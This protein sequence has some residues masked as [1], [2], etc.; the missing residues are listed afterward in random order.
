SATTA[1]GSN[2]NHV[3]LF[4]PDRRCEL[5]AEIMNCFTSSAS[6]TSTVSA[7]SPIPNQRGQRALSSV[8][9]CPR[10][11]RVRRRSSD[12]TTPP[13][14][15]HHGPRRLQRSAA[16]QSAPLPHPAPRLAASTSLP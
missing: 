1:Q 5:H 11:E 14:R 4:Q 16:P 15:L 6:A 3:R 12:R 13:P 10:V 8:R 9:T 7:A 2:S